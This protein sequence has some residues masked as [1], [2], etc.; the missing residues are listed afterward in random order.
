MADE[1]IL[2]FSRRLAF[3]IKVTPLNLFQGDLLK[4]K[5]TTNKTIT[6]I[7]ASNMQSTYIIMGVSGCGKST[8]AQKLS[9]KTRIP[10]VDADDFH[11][12]GNIEKMSKGIPLNDEDRLP[13]L[14]NLNSFLQ[15]EATN[16]GT[17]LACSALKESY[18]RILSKNISVTWIYLKGDFNTIYNRLNKREDHFMDSSLLQSQFDTLEE[19]TYGT[20]I[21]ID[22]N[23]ETI[24]QSILNASAMMKNSLGIIGLGVMG[25]SL[26]L[27]AAE[28]GISVSVYNRASEGEEFIVQNFLEENKDFSFCGHTNLENFV[29]SLE[30]PRKILL[31]VKAGIVVDKVIESIVPYLSQDDI[32]IDGGNSYYPDT[33][34]RFEE[35]D[36]QGI[37]FIGMGVSGGESGA[38]KGPSMMPG[39]TYDSYTKVA[40]ILETLAAEDK[41]GNSC[42]AY[43]G[44]EGSGHFV[45][46]IHNGMEYGE[47]QLLAEVYQ[48][49]SKTKSYEEIATILSEWNQGEHHSYLLE[50]TIKILQEKD[51]NGYILDQ[52]LD[53]SG[54]KGTGSWSV[55]TALELGKAPS[56]MT[57]ALFERYISSLKPDRESFS[58]RLSI[59]EE[60]PEAI[61][62]SAL[63][64]AFLFAKTINLQQG[65][66]VI[67]N[68]S[69]EYDWDIN[70]SEVARIWTN[71]CIIKSTQMEVISETF[72]TVS[73]LLDD[74]FTFEQLS[75]NEKATQK[76]IAYAGKHRIPCSCF[77][78]A[79]NYWISIT[80]EKLPANLI[81]AQRDFF[82]AHTFQKIG[83]PTGEFHHHQWNKS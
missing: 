17:I 50:T 41:S 6:T 35:L 25:K 22:Q 81:Q 71:G 15:K 78:N 32:L 16:K 62:L 56:V 37:H 7:L 39:G 69:N 23:P 46:M 61:D 9:E 24:V 13:W 66:E 36:E 63:K 79:F 57:A 11:P 42:C 47:M 72:K 29:H 67:R 8:I 43:V 83:N 12:T 14:K 38:R 53:K 26:A 64:D 73:N 10:F 68:A 58:K 33:Q 80:S 49:L 28:K 2:L 1:K 18:R 65:F 44:K 20:H 5:I 74:S 70:L 31:M 30:Q 52:I 4:S 76:M 19:P 51:D 75:K 3:I 59:S 55:R 54:S 40:D 77:S 45:K 34:R 82:G 21:S 60:S 48:L 27:N